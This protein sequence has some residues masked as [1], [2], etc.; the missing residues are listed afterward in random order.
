MQNLAR[1]RIESPLNPYF[2]K[3][4]GNKMNGYTKPLMIILKQTDS[5]PMTD[6][7]FQPQIINL[8]LTY[9]GPKMNVHF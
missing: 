6:V 2:P 3:I 4:T 1:Y 5:G 8:K 9:L 7:H